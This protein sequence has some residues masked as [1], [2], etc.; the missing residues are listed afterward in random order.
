MPIS[1]WTRSAGLSVEAWNDAWVQHPSR[2]LTLELSIHQDRQ[3]LQRSYLD[4]TIIWVQQK[5]ITDT[6]DL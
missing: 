4:T 3:R 5:D 1:S 6:T 2:P